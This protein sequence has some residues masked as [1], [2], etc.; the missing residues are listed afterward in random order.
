MRFCRIARGSIAELIDDFDVCLDEDF[1][2]E[3]LASQLKQDADFLITRS[4][5]DISHL[6][7]QLSETIETRSK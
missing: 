7:P 3:D 4:N 1:V 5:G 6:K 2:E